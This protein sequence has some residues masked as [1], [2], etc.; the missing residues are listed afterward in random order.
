MP[1]NAEREKSRRDESQQEETRDF[2]NTRRVS[3]SFGS[4][5][6]GDD[7]G[8]KSERQSRRPSLL[9]KKRMKNETKEAPGVVIMY[10]YLESRAKDRSWQTPE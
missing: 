6:P 7:K 1:S 3:I 4:G 2:N 10:G 8:K 9:R 5:G